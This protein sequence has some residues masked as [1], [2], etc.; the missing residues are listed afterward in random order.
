MM[1][2]KLFRTLFLVRPKSLGSL[3]PPLGALWTSLGLLRSDLGALCDTPGLAG[4]RFG[5][6]WMPSRRPGAPKED[7]KISTGG[8]HGTPELI[9]K[10]IELDVAFEHS[11]SSTNHE[12]SFKKLCSLN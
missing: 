7:P 9:K 1:V 6:P 2:L 5:A 8:S 4:V 11:E 3:R 10:A 12:Y